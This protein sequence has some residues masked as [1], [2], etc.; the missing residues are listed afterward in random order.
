MTKQ[1]EFRICIALLV[2]MITM[3]TLLNWRRIPH[4][5]EIEMQYDREVYGMPD[6][7]GTY[8]YGSSH[9][10]RDYDLTGHCY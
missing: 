5:Y 4:L 9:H 3:A 1:F 6:D 2:L 7:T 10:Y 8:R